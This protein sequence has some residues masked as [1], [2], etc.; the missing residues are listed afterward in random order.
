MRH[1]F[2]LKTTSLLD[3]FWY[4]NVYNNNSLKNPPIFAETNVT[5][6]EG[7]LGLQCFQLLPPKHLRHWT[8][9]DEEKKTPKH[10]IIRARDPKQCGGS[11]RIM[12]YNVIGDDDDDGFVYPMPMS[13]HHF[14]I[15]SPIHSH[16]GF[17]TL[18]VTI[19]TSSTHSPLD[20]WPPRWQIK[21]WRFSS[22]G[23]STTNGACSSTPCLI[24]GG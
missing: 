9:S 14:R 22:L 17:A 19:A 1:F 10:R 2:T 18:Q 13:Y 16:S 15:M 11:R 20:T 6:S 24:N 4:T 7:H 21:V 5:M 23:K 8:C 3:V 12:Y